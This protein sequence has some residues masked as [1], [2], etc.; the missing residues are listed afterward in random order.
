[1]IIVEALKGSITSMCVCAPA[2]FEFKPHMICFKLYIMY[3]WFGNHG[4]WLQSKNKVITRLLIATEWTLIV[5]MNYNTKDYLSNVESHVLVDFSNFY[6]FEK[7]FSLKQQIWE[8]VF[9]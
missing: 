3:K 7:L 1:M 2:I 9:L 5:E 8:V 4:S 6:K